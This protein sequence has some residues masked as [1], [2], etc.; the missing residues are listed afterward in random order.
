MAKIKRN[1]IDF[2]KN[3][4]VVKKIKGN[5]RQGYKKVTFQLLEDKLYALQKLPFEIR[6]KTGKKPTQIDLINEAVDLLFKKY[7]KKLAK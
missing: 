5:T 3:D 1:P 2:I 7:E 6:E 4:P